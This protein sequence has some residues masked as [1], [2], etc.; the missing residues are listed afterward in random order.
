[1]NFIFI[2]AIFNFNFPL[3]QNSNIYNIGRY[4]YYTTSMHAIFI[5]HS[6]KF[7]PMNGVE[8]ILQCENFSSL[9]KIFKWTFILTK[10]QNNNDNEYSNI[11][12]VSQRAHSHQILCGKSYSSWLQLLNI[13]EEC[14]VYSNQIFGIA[15]FSNN[16]AKIQ[17]QHT[18]C[19]CMCMC[20]H[21]CVCNARS[22]FWFK[23]TKYC[24]L[25]NKTIERKATTFKKIDTGITSV[26][27]GGLG[28]EGTAWSQRF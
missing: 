19:M 20:K 15:I 8:N 17:T 3:S 25:F 22:A 11:H 28:V 10:Q 18:I 7:C 9:S 1:M 24:I 5:I 26:F 12:S 23:M 21:I 27:R 13:C 6:T 2:S 16:E 4:T 14:I